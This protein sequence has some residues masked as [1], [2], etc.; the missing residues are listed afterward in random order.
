MLDS[1]ILDFWAA[2]GLAPQMDGVCREEGTHTWASYDSLLN[3]P[4]GEEFTDATPDPDN[5]ASSP[6]LG[7]GRQL[8][9]KKALTQLRLAPPLSA[10]VQI[11]LDGN[12]SKMRTDLERIS[13]NLGTTLTLS[14]EEWLTLMP[15]CHIKRCLIIN[16]MIHY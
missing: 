16:V 12:V 15:K 10:P 9:R 1:S 6:V 8:R 4:P 5:G 2:S 3:A 13:D 14:G 11:P 7:R